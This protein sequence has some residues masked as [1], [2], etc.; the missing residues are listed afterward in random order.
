M[1]CMNGTAKFLHAVG[2]R[3]C[4]VGPHKDLPFS[5]VLMIRMAGFSVNQLTPTATVGGDVSMGAL[6][7]MARPGTEAVT[8]A[9]IGKLSHV[10]AQLIFAV[11]GS[12]V[13]LYGL[14]LPEGGW[15][16]LI[17]GSC[18]LG[19]GVL[20]FLFAQQYGKFG[21]LLR[22]MVAHGLGGKAL[23]NASQQISQID[24]EMK[25]YYQSSYPQFVLSVFWNVLALACGILQTWFFFHFL[26]LHPS[27]LVVSAVWFLATWFE[28][29]SFAIP[30]NFGVLEGTS[31]LTL[32]IAGFSSSLGL[33]YGIALRIGQLFWSA[34][35][36][37]CYFILIKMYSHR[38]DP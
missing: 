2:W 21:A 24:E 16:A 25:R 9:L 4:L 3:F 8:S 5:Q 17:T 33:A 14:S 18:L 6:L 19:S 27:F 1:I 35:G 38:A 13:I 36:L 23:Q 7:A 12:V 29:V 32:K 30:S 26:N 20:A 28:I 37:L 10:L 22:W 15:V 31:V 11:G 34:V